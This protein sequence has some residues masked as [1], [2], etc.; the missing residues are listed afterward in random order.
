MLR[1]ARSD[2]ENAHKKG[3]GQDKNVIPRYNWSC[4]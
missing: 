1:L 2:R 4:V 3:K